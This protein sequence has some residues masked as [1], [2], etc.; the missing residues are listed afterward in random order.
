MIFV[1]GR[2]YC[3]IY[4]F[5]KGFRIFILMGKL[6]ITARGVVKDFLR[7]FSAE[8][9]TR[10]FIYGGEEGERYRLVDGVRA[11]L[12]IRGVDVFVDCDDRLPEDLGEEFYAVYFWDVVNRTHRVE[13]LGNLPSC[14]ES[15]AGPRLKR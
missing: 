11:G 7:E 5:K 12:C 9:K 1:L 6:E 14:P 3:R 4:F 8:G 2:L 15:Y 13:G 10:I